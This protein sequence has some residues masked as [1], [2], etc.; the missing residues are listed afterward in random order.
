MWGA[1]GRI[2]RAGA[3]GAREEDRGE[4]PAEDEVV[5]GVEARE[6]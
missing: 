6:E 3:E 1:S 4:G 2:L 5:G